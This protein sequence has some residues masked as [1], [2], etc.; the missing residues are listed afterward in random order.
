M[1]YVLGIDVG[2]G[3]ARCGV[4]D[5]DAAL[6]GVGKH[7]IALHR[8]DTDHVEQSSE[9]IWSAICSSVAEALKAARVD[10]A[11]VSALSYSA[12]CSLVLLDKAHN[13][14]PLSTTDMPWNI[15]MWM[16]H[17]ATAE[18]EEVNA[19][20][21]P[22]LSNLGGAM[23]VEMQIPKLMW[24][25][26]HRPEIWEQLGYAGDLAD[27]LCFKSTGTFERSACTLGC[28]WTFDPDAGGWNTAF[29]QSVGL[30][31]LIDRA[32]LPSH[33]TAI[34]TN[35]GTL[36]DT[37]A[38]DLGLTTACTVGMG[39]ID[40]HAGALGTSGLHETGTDRRVALIAGTSNCHIALTKRRTEVPGV[41][42]PY[43][44][45]VLDD[46]YALEGG[47][48]ATGA[49]L[50][51]ILAMFRAPMDKPHETLGQ[52]FLDGLQ[53]DA[54][55]GS[56]ICVLPDFLGNRSPFADPTMRGAIL[57]LSLE[58][59]E[60]M[61]PKL[62]G[63]TALGIAFGTRQIIDAMRFAGL[64]INAID[65][66]GGHVKSDLLVQLYA[67]ATDCDLCLPAC[68]EPV[69]LGAACAAAKATAENSAF[70]RAAAKAPARLVKSNPL[71]SSNLQTR[72]ESFSNHYPKI[73]YQP[74][75]MA[76]AL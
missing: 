68:A 46:W 76:K 11:D 14:L 59:P 30:S 58:D 32:A 66:S 72:Y 16:D 36:T 12:T 67:D 26:R 29:L 4:F 40:A 55:Y 52:A 28:K 39:L 8:P 74:V 25:K 5:A 44:G 3:S 49:A 65:L 50:D 24:V 71:R 23:S 48:S 69:L 10:G 45:A 38:R 7:A 53:A 2:S 27:F 43:A 60:T 33:A 61:L 20:G 19:T 34:G 22:V 42:G 57:G 17:R 56:E 62:Y 18:T 15:V 35:V 73:E 13:P 47:Q 9:D 1:T 6:I 21:S 64:P 31:D 41:W 51:Q 37:A 54:D 70:H 63:A 75:T